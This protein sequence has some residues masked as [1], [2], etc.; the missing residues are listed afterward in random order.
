MN[1]NQ[2]KV[3]VTG[4]GGFIGSHLAERLVHLGANVK[5]FVKYN[6]RQDIGLLKFIDKKILQKMEI[7][8]GDIL[9]STGLKKAMKGVDIVFHLGALISIPYSYINPHN[10]VRVNIL[11][12]MNIMRAALEL[13]INKI[14]HTSTSEVYGTAQYVPVD[15]KHSLKGQSP[16]SASK[17]GAD[18]LVES[19]YCS[20]NLPI[21]TIRPFNTYGPRQSA[22]AVIPTIISQALT[23]DKIRLG[24]IHPTRDFTFVDDTVDGFIKMAE[25][26]NVLGETINIGTGYEISIGE[27]AKKIMALTG[28]E[29]KIVTDPNR[30]R[31]EKSEVNRLVCSSEKAQK[32]IGWKANTSLENGLTKTINWIEKNLFFYSPDHYQI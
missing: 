11:G 16:Y 3:L 30:V 27:L 32:L 2:T 4:S 31:P 5:C 29:L 28:K 24:S 19:F 12:T 6:S 9:D 23:R 25:S 21:T 7:L 13:G 20:Y 22:R 10:V 26:S 8:H 18:K 15:E 1:W 14:I 17:I